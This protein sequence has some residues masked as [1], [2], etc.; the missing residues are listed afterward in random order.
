MVAAAPTWADEA[1][2]GVLAAQ[3]GLL[4][5]AGWLGWLQLR[6]QVRPFVVVDLDERYPPL[7]QLRITNVGATMARN[8]QFRFDPAIRSTFDTETGS[9]GKVPIGALDMFRQGIGSFPPGREFLVFFDDVR[10]RLEKGY[11]HRYEVTVTYEGRP[12]NRSFT[13]RFVLDIET[14]LWRSQVHR[15]ELHDVATELEKIRVALQRPSRLGT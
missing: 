8:V 4:A 2:L 9:E 13:D 12:L 1:I 6:E 15:K 3:L 14:F 11:E 5:L 10:A 7:L